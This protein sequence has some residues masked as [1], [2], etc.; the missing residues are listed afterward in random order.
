M[1]CDTFQLYAS[2][3]IHSQLVMINEDILVSRE[4]LSIDLI[5]L[6][7]RTVLHTVNIPTHF[8]RI[9]FLLSSTEHVD[10]L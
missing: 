9:T 6:D 3:P 2:D 4:E 10:S 7:G 8:L 5:S 1:R